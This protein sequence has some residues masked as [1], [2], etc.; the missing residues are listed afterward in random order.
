M[1]EINGRYYPD[2]YKEYVGCRNCKHQPKP[3]MMCE[4]GDGRD[5]VE[6]ICSGWELKGANDD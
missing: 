2:E 3:L 1:I 5:I 4:W 6:L